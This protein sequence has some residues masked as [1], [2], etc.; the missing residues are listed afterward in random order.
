M[1]AKICL[2]TGA[3]SGIGRAT[4]L[5]LREAGHIVYGAARRVQRM[6]ELRQAGGHPVAM[7][8]TRDDD[9]DRVVRTVLDEQQ[10][11]DVLI[12]NAGIG[13]HGALEDVP[14][15][16]ARHL[17][18]VNV[19][20][21]ARLIQLALP[22]LREQRSG[23]IVNVSSIAGEISLPLVGWY[24]ASKHALESYSD[25]LRQECKPFGID[26]VVIQP[27]IIKTEF[28]EDTPR[29]LR[30]VSGRGPYAKL[31]ESMA[32]RAE[33][34]TKASDPAVVAK[35]IRRLLE[36]PKP[37]VRYPVGYLARTILALNKLLPDRTFDS[38]V[39]K[40]DRT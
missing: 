6:D 4:A 11:I 23:T 2:V 19:F 31:A 39:T 29:E 16:R 27:G 10:R 30:A 9:L 40:I 8:V 17:F 26:V 36:S 21:P 5:E 32:S 33:N 37:R 7:D 13:L 28:E 34:A 14:V 12:N 3:S 35:T 1:A 38:M 15:E 24:H 25:S 18:D 20:G 22:Y